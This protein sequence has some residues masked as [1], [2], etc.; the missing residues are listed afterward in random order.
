MLGGKNPHPQTYVVGGMAIPLDRSS[1][2][3]VNDIVLNELRGLLTKGRNFVR[4]VY[5]PD[6]LAIAKAYPEWAGI[7]KGLGTYLS[8]GDLAE[9]PPKPRTLQTDGA[10]P[11]GIVRD[12]DLSKVER[13]DPAQVAEYV[14]HS[15]YRYKGGDSVGLNPYQGETTPA[16]TGP[17]PPY[18]FL[19]VEAKYSWLKAPRYGGTAVEVGPLAR[20]VV[21]YARGNPAVKKLVDGAL[22]ELRAGPEAL[23]STLGRTAARGLETAYLADYSLTLLDRLQDNIGSGDLQIANTTKWQPGSWPKRSQGVGFEEAPRGTLSHW[24]VIDDGK[25]DNYQAVVPST[26]NGSPRD[27]RGQ[28]G[29]YEAALVGTPVADP[30][31]PLEILRTVHSF[32]PCMACAAHV[33]DADGNPVVEVRVQ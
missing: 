20:M 17:K 19:D 9:A 11:G 5:V 31:Q 25:V 26:W 6:L 33:V 16:Y 29:A 7:G 8:A 30:R 22:K 32:D 1:Q 3:A 18:E 4:Q 27:A 13:V 2:Y 21:A 28:R 14:T 12:G 24:I 15:W 10:L 23:F